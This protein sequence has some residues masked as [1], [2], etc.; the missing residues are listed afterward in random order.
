MQAETGWD[1]ATLTTKPTGR[2]PLTSVEESRLIEP[3]GSTRLALG[4]VGYWVLQT[5]TNPIV[6]HR[7]HTHLALRRTAGRVVIITKTLIIAKDFCTYTIIFLRQE[8]ILRDR[9]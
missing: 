4:Y 6:I 1:G 8:N 5:P 9:N 2:S 3:L 7:A